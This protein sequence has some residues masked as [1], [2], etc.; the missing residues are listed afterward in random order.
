MLSPWALARKF[1]SI[2]SLST[3][4]ILASPMSLTAFPNC[5]RPLKVH[6]RL[7]LIKASSIC[8][9]QADGIIRR[10]K[11]MRVASLRLHWSVPEKSMAHWP[12][13]RANDLW[14]YVQEDSAADAFLLA[15]EDS[16][17]W[18]GHE[19]FFITSSQTAYEEDTMNLIGLHWPDVPIKGILL[20]NQGLFDCSKAATL[21]GWQ[22]R[23]RLK[24]GNTTLED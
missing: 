4:N 24:G 12:G 9:I 6:N 3:R 11:S 5:E 18:S 8:E 7:F 16:D 19:R 13:E 15:I 2:I 17:K 10:Y 1:V 20:G 23:D 14:G 22:H 21:L